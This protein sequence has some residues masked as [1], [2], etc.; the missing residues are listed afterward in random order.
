MNEISNDELKELVDFAD[1][2]GKTIK[3]I[4]D[5]KE[6]FSKNLKIEYYEFFPVLSLRKTALHDPATKVFK[7][8]FDIV[9]SVIVIIGLLSWLTPI[10][11]ILIKLES[12]GPVFFRQGRPGIDEKEFFCYKFRSMKIYLFV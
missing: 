9:F 7:R 12:R 5:T 6:I 8:T 1:E 10:F 4:P 2:N 3:F 11:A